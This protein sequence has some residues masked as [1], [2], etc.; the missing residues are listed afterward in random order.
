[1]SNGNLPAGSL[2][3]ISRFERLLELRLRAVHIEDTDLR[4]IG[5]LSGLKTLSLQKTETTDSGLPWLYSPRNLTTQLTGIQVTAGG[6]AKPKAAL[7]NCAVSWDSALSAEINASM[8]PGI[9]RKHVHGA[10]LE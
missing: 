9:R 7:P 6:V 5:E 8:F 10:C 1:L 4:G 2:V 3:A